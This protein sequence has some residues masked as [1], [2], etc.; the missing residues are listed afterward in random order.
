MASARVGVTELGGDEVDG[1][2]LTIDS[3]WAAGF[4]E[5]PSTVSL[6][7]SRDAARRPLNG[8][9]LLPILPPSVSIRVH[10]WLLSPFVHCLDV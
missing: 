8:R 5:Q 1:R 7:R 3:P 9:I 4:H 6:P 10:L 2:V